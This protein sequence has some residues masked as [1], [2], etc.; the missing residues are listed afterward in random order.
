MI[1][2]GETKHSTTVTRLDSRF[3]PEDSLPCRRIGTTAQ[4]VGEMQAPL[5]DTGEE[6]F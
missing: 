3:A 6:G 1:Q 5:L 2:I 4:T